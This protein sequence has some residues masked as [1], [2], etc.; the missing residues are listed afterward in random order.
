MS[1]LREQLL[2]SPKLGLYLQEIQSVLLEER[3]KRE[4]F[5][6]TMTE[7]EKVEFINGQIVRQS[8]VRLAHSRVSGALFVLLRTFVRQHDLGEVGHEKL[9]VSLTRNDYEPDICFFAR[10]KSAQFQPGQMRF[11]APDLIVE[12]LSDTTEGNDRG[13][14]FEDYAAHG[15]AEYWIIDPVQ[16]V[17]EQYVLQGGAY[18]LRLKSDSGVLKSVAVPGFTL[19]IRAIFDERENL[20]TLQKMLSPEG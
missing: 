12:V 9:L 17:I 13:V 1:A 3:K 14:K 10:D 6:K 5:Y 15:V 18:Q 16:E 2:H 19:P 7:Q 4:E 8:P 11:P 20:V